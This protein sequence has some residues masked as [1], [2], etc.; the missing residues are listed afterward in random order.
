M[1]KKIYSAAGVILAIIFLVAGAHA[2]DT[3]PVG[4]VTL[5]WDANVEPDLKGYKILV[6]KASRKTADPGAMI[7]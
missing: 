4:Q 3:W 2:V 5:A 6:S 1:N 7:A